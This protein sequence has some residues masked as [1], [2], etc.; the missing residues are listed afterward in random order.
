MTLSVLIVC[1]VLN[2]INMYMKN[3]S[4]YAALLLALINFF[5]FYSYLKIPNKPVKSVL[6]I[7]LAQ[8]IT[9]IYDMTLDPSMNIGEAIMNLGLVWLITLVALLIHLIVVNKEIDKT[10]INKIKFIDRLKLTINYERNAF[11]VRVYYKVIL[12]STLISIIM[13]TANSNMLNTLNNNINVRLYGSI[14]VL[15]PILIILSV[16]ST[17]EIAF[18]LLAIY[19][20]IQSFTVY[21]LYITDN[22]DIITFLYLILTIAVI[23][24]SIKNYIKIQRNICK[25]N[26][27]NN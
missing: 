3:I 15:F 16:L 27:K 26:K 6:G 8:F 12:Y 17:S 19:T 1:I 4:I 13:I 9:I 22:L 7:S 5:T 18:E 25:E 2:V 21:N 14:A 24:Y 23:V 20:L 10:S 11:K